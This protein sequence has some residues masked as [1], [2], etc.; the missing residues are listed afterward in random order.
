MGGPSRSPSTSW[1]SAGGSQ[2]ADL[3]EEALALAAQGVAVFPVG[4]DKKPRNHNGFKG[5]TTDPAIIEKWDWNGGGAIGAAIPDGH[6]VVDIDPR[7]GGDRTV[8]ALLKARQVLPGTRTVS[9]QSGGTHRYY[10]LPDGVEGKLRGTIGPGMDIKASG[11]GYVLVPPS[12]GYAL[13]WDSEIA[14]APQWMLDEI[15]VPPADPTTQVAS[16]PKFLPFVKGTPYGL[17]AME[18]EIEQLRSS[19]EGSRNN[20]LNKASFAI[21]QLVAGGELESDHALKLLVAGAE[22]IGLHAA[23]LMQTLRS[24]WEAGQEEPRQAPVTTPVIETATLSEVVKELSF[25]D[26]DGFFTDY[27]NADAIGP[28][29]YYCEPLVPKN[30]YILVYGPTE[31]SKSMVFLALAAEASH[32]GIKTTIYSLENPRHIDIDRINRWNPNPDNLRISHELLDLSDPHQLAALLRR[33]KEW[34]TDWILLDTYSHAFMSRSED[35]NAKAIHFAKIIRHILHELDCSVIVV[36]HTGYS[37]HG[38]PR[39]ASAKRQ[40][41]DMSIKMERP[42]GFIW[43]PN[44]PSVFTMVNTKSAR[45]GNPFDRV[46]RIHDV[47]GDTRDLELRWDRGSDNLI[48]PDGG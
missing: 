36:D 33:E 42:A 40:A 5:A 38:E 35:G 15:V 22:D 10:K 18:R 8:A 23:E 24:G 31:A 3:K 29:E 45:F 26:E 13:K 4:Q 14:E 1:C 11:K 12:P 34:D 17:S 46:G 21:S 32:K 2:L 25:E 47:V 28:P 30:A 44:K 41:V 7:N 39:D 27:V 16:A 9:T 48:W 37:A 43:E 6:F 19:G 20:A